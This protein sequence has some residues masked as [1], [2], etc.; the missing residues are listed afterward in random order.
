MDSF[1]IIITPIAKTDL[2]EIRDYI[3]YVLGVPH[4]AI[5]YLQD[6]HDQI[7]KLSYLADSIAPVSFEPWHARGVRK[8]I[9]KNFYI[10]YWINR[11]TNQVY[12]IAILYNRRDQLKALKNVKL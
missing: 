11:D 6:I 10:Y 1:Q 4:I 7:N 2:L 3:A 9:F 8:I 5:Q 12:V